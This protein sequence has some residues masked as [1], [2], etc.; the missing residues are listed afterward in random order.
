[1]YFRRVC[2]VI[3]VALCVLGCK[4][5]QKSEPAA[6]VETKEKK[7]MRKLSLSFPT[8]DGQQEG[9]WA[10]GSENGYIYPRKGSIGDALKKIA[11]DVDFNSVIS[12]LVSYEG[13]VSLEGIEQLPNLEYL[14]IMDCKVEDISPVLKLPKL[15]EIHADNNLIQVVPDLSVLTNLKV[16]YLDNNP[17]VD[18]ANLRKLTYLEKVYFSYYPPDD[19]EKSDEAFEICNFLEKNGV[20]ST[21]YHHYLG[22]NPVIPEGV[23]SDPTHLGYEVENIYG[24]GEEDGSENSGE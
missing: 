7:Q 1:M 5:Q 15:T 13:L 2:A 11:D 14:D 19:K 16:L 4:N 17:L 24:N 18:F 12:L 9:W 22:R 3:L 6:V 21:N 10:V 23:A 8:D 20:K